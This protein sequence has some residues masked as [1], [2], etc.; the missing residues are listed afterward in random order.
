MAW[1]GIKKQAAIS[2]AA[3]VCNLIDFITVRFYCVLVYYR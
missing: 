3:V 1:A 2:T